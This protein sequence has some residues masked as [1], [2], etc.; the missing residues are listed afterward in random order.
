MKQV[1]FFFAALASVF[2]VC[3][4]AFM[5]SIWSEGKQ[6]ELNDKYTEV[7]NVC[8]GE[9]VASSAVYDPTASKN[10]AIAVE[11]DSRDN[12]DAYTSAIPDGMLAQG[13]SETALVLCLGSEEKV[14]IESCPY[15]SVGDDS[16][17]TKNVI[18]RYRYEREASLIVA[19]TGEVLVEELLYGATPAEC[20]EEE[21]FKRRQK[22]VERK[23]NSIS[24]VALQSWVQQ[25]ITSS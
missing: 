16:E 12:L 18:E 9:T 1:I 8:R 3:I 19:Q 22:T 17:E 6:S 13:S 15:Y 7:M 5:F 25:A 21:S 23:G 14:M 24:D 4:L 2:V 10:L 11:I 20:G